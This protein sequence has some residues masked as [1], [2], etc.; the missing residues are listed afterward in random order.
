MSKIIKK[1]PIP[2][3]GLM[4]ALAAGG[5][6]VASFGIMYKNIFGG[7][8]LLIGGLLTYKIVCYRKKVMEKLNHP[9]IGS[10]APTYSMGLI[11]LSTYFIKVSKSFATGM[12]YIGIIIHLLL[13]VRFTQ[14]FILNFNIKK[15][16]PSY[17][18]VYVGIVCASVTAPAYNQ[19]GLGQIIFWFGFISYLILLP[20][21]SYR[22]FKIKSIPT[23][24]L[25]TIA[26]YAAPAS[27]CLAGYMSSFAS[28]NLGLV[29]ILMT[30]SIISYVA[31]VLYMPKML[32][33]GFYPSYSAF[34]FPMVISAIGL[35]KTV[36]YFKKME[37]SSGIIK[38]IAI[39]ERY[40][41]IFLVVFVLFSYMTYLL[42]KD[43]VES[44][45]K[46]KR[47]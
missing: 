30:L 7:L 43:Q 35:A 9:V 17:F 3:A 11:V 14:K 1:L 13:L 41:A 4:L 33:G 8:S 37:I 38:S 19:Q 46:I 26:I 29:Y 39:V 16:F 22:V 34:T 12:W 20:I 31:V 45:E 5:N 10:V 47:A 23:P 6:L 42:K 15:V 21:V 24:A 44:N 25:P 27:L 2:I 32:K 18:I 36:G 40:F 28:K